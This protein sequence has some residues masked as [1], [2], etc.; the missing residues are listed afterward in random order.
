VFL[1]HQDRNGDEPRLLGPERFKEAVSYVEE[2]RLYEPALAIW[3]GTDQYKVSLFVAISALS[4]I[5]P[6]RKF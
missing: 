5:I 3:K 6:L 1:L 4:L 2:H